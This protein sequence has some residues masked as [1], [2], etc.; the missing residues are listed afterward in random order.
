MARLP[1]P[2]HNGPL[3]AQAQCLPA[4]IALSPASWLSLPQTSHAW[5]K[6]LL[7]LLGTPS[8]V[9][10]FGPCLPSL[11]SSVVPRLG[12]PAAIATVVP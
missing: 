12:A 3:L 9:L 7:S 5:E 1:C 10:P 2:S 6:G 4:G 8:G 11:G